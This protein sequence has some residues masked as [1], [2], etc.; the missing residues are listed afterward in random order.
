[1]PS[2]ESETAARTLLQ[3]HSD[4][5][6]RTSLWSAGCIDKLAIHD[7]VLQVSVRLGFPATQYRV[8]LA[9]ALTRLLG[10]AG[11]RKVNVDVDWAVQA[12]ART[13]TAQALPNIKNII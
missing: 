9:D 8:E 4:P 3:Q 11:I 7:D 10:A 6:L 12:Q 5:Y 1:M 13:T 2:I